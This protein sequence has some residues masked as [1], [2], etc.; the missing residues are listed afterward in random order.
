MKYTFLGTR[1]RYQPIP[2][3]GETCEVVVYAADFEK[4]AQK[5]QELLPWP[6]PAFVR[7]LRIEEEPKQDKW[8]TN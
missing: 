2:P 1:Q 6:G 3:T 4:A 8:K 7:I 5:A